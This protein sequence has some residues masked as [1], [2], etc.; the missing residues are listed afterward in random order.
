[1]GREEFYMGVVYGNG[2]W[3]VIYFW[4]CVNDWLSRF[5]FFY[6]AK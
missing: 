2:L 3:W 1:M 4:E 6:S 5:F